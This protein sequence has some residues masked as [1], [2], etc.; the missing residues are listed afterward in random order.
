MGIF[1]IKA[2]SRAYAPAIFPPES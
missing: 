2:P 1:C